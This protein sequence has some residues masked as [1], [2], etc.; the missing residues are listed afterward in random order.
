M[1][2]TETRPPQIAATYDAMYTSGGHEGVYQLPYR[3]S[4]YYPLFRAVLAE[5]RRRD[6]RDVLEVGCGVGTFASMLFDR[7]A[8]GYSGFDF[9]PVA[10]ATA[11]R[12]T[13]RQDAFRVGDATR[14][15]SYA[16]PYKAIVCTEV[17]EHIEADRGAVALW[18][19]G[20]DC[21][22]SVPNFDSDTHV[23]FFKSEGD[24]RQR[25]GD[26]IDIRSIRR[27]KLPALTDLSWRSYL[28]ALRWNRYRPKRL[29]DILGFSSFDS[30]GWF[31]F[32]GTRRGE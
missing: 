23:R 11:I 14:E 28:Q 3:R 12:R 20:T 15:E 25:Y 9:S 24:V 19:P 2:E 32:A 5:L 17:L 7:T 22:C 18:R 21:I 8:I 13:G 1:S 31:L 27:I 30:G 29:L 10:V 6:A 26:L 16:R 4:R